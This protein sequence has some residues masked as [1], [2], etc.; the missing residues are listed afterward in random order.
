VTEEKT[1]ILQDGAA[2]IIVDGIKAGGGMPDRE[3]PYVQNRNRPFL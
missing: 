2:I 1:M 3:A